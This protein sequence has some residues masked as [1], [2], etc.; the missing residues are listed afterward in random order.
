M[1]ARGDQERKVDGDQLLRDKYN[2]RR[3]TFD[4]NQEKFL[5]PSVL[6][7]YEVPVAL[8]AI[9]NGEPDSSDSQNK[10][11]SKK[12]LE[13]QSTMY[14]Q[15]KRFFV[16]KD[17]TWEQALSIAEEVGR[18]MR[19]AAQQ[20]QPEY[21]EGIDKTREIMEEC[22]SW[23]VLPRARLGP[24]S[25]SNSID[26]RMLEQPRLADGVEPPEA[27]SL[28][29]PDFIPDA[30]Y[31]ELTPDDNW[32]LKRIGTPKFLSQWDAYTES[33]AI[34]PLLDTRRMMSLVTTK[35][36]GY[37][38]ESMRFPTRVSN[39]QAYE[40]PEFEAFWDITSEDLSCLQREGYARMLEWLDQVPARCQIVDIFHVAFFDGSAVPDGG[41][42]MMIM[43]EK[44]LPTPR[45]MCHEKTNLH[46][47]ETSESLSYNMRLHW[48]KTRENK[49][50]I[51]AI[52]QARKLGLPSPITMPVLESPQVMQENRPCVV[53]LRPAELDDASGILSIFNWYAARS[54]LSSDANPTSVEG[55]RAIIQTIRTQNLPMIVVA[56]PRPE[57]V[58]GKDWLVAPEKERIMGFA[59]VTLL[60]ASDADVFTGDLY[61][62]VRPEEKRNGY[63]EALVDQI[64]AAVDRNYIRQ[65]TM[66]FRPKPS[67][68]PDPNPRTLTAI[69]C[70]IT[71]PASSIGKYTWIAGW[72]KNNFGFKEWGVLE[73]SRV[74]FGHL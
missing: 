42:S 60:S 6:V 48:R 39:P 4:L 9:T 58:V 74:K 8:N 56:D 68:V 25:N 63:G 16:P 22:A 61:I 72:M 46:W 66:L 43:N 35:P 55:I 10:S 33:P 2:R 15:T 28:N 73:G 40:Q 19:V 67:H 70:R 59:Y 44:H 23:Y 65:T 64:L 36:P 13:T 20:R 34:Y 26:Y 21:L 38:C 31:E 3:V 7:T 47:H 24:G 50:A 27:W 45:D 5:H 12:R 14:D 29:P 17:L 11:L 54:P 53:Y 18:V 37:I 32:R 71:Y 51:K 30:G 69:T 62:F 57:P 1:S 41:L 49:A 52:Q